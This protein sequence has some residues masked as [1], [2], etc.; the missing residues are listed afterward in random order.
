MEFGSPENFRDNIEVRLLLIEKAIAQYQFSAKHLKTQ[1]EDKI[2]QHTSFFVKGLGNEINFLSSF[3][4]LFFNSRELL[5]A[6]LAKLNSETTGRD[7][8]TAQKFLPFSK[9]MMKGDYDSNNLATIEFLKTN[10]TYIFHIRKVRNEIKNSPSNVKFRYAN[11]F[12]AYFKVPI[13]DDELELIKFLDIENKDEALRNKFYYCTYKLDEIF[14]E[15]LLFWKSCF[16]ILD[17]DINALTSTS[18]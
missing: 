8:Q 15:M 16:S 6:L 17:N 13:K 14:P 11:R 2:D 1:F 4:E 9:K 10:I 3:K 12:E 18:T 5:D 7:S